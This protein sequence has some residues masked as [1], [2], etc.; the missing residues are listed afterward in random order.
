MCTYILS[1]EEWFAV[2]VKSNRERVTSLGLIGK[3]YEVFLPEYSKPGANGRRS[4]HAPLFPGYLFCRFDATNRL[5]ILTLPGVVHIV[6]LG[7]T[8]AP[9]DATELESL[10]VI[11][12][13]GLPLN[14]DESYTVGETVRIDEGPLAGVFGVIVGQKSQRLLV[15]ITLLQ[16]SVSVALEREWICRLAP[17]RDAAMTPAA[18]CA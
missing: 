2:R 8:P 12:K 16:R 5:P 7:K 4:D 13:T 9:V 10:K 11:L 14:A 1:S 18:S 17:G 15:S 6:G 3:G